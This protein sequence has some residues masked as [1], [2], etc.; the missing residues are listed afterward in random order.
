MEMMFLVLHFASGGAVVMPQLYPPD[1]CQQAISKINSGWF[2]NAGLCVP[3]PRKIAGSEQHIMTK[4]E[5]E[6]IIGT[7]INNGAR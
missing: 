2:I 4:K 5:F 3:A 1:E 6:A 7:T